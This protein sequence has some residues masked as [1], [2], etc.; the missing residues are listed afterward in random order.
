[1][2]IIQ[3]PDTAEVS[4]L[5]KAAVDAVEADY[6]LPLEDIGPFL[7]EKFSVQPAGFKCPGMGNVPK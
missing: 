7:K 2:V 1:M 4:Y 3:D 5:P 6:I